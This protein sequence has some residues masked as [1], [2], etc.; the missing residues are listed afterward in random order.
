MSLYFDE[1]L[2]HESLSRKE[3]FNL[4][5]IYT[6]TNNP[7][8]K[9]HCKNK[10]IKSF[11]KIVCKYALFYSKK[12][13]KENYDTILD[14]L[15]T[16]GIIGLSKALDKFDPD[17]GVHISVFSKSFI[18]FAIRWEAIKLKNLIHVPYGGA[19]F[20]KENWHARVEMKQNFLS[21]NFIDKTQ[22]AC[23]NCN[24]SDTQQTIIKV[25][26]DLEFSEV[27]RLRYID[28][29]TYKDISDITNIPKRKIPKIIKEGLPTLQNKL[30]DLRRELYA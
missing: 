18:V 1:V 13:Y 24:T 15:I 2:N 29:K 17:K 9:Q 19:A 21:T 28:G 3:M 12:Y 30:K 23:V 8:Q 10:L 4:A 25:I 16:A 26:D 14:D 20:K 6:I 22:S 27:F 5:K 11:G 7:Q